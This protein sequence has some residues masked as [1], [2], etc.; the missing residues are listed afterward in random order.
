MYAIAYPEE[1]KIDRPMRVD[2]NRSRRSKSTVE[3]RP[4]SATLTFCT[5]D[6]ATTW[7]DTAKRYLSYDEG[8]CKIDYVH[9][10]FEEGYWSE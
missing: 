6:A 2:F 5:I 4:N 1:Y 10:Y 8:S 7:L 9:Y 3:R